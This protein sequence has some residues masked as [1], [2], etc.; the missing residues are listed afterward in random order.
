MPVILPYEFD[1]HV[2]KRRGANGRPDQFT[3]GVWDGVLTVRSICHILPI[4]DALTTLRRLLEGA[5]EAAAHTIE[6][7]ND[8][9]PRTFPGR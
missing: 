1:L 9:G 2:L 7:A 4:D 5:G 8:H 6:E 3:I